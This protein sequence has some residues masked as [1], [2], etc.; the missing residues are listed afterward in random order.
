M[1]TLD[2]EWCVCVSIARSRPLILSATV[3]SGFRQPESAIA[4]TQGR[5]S[6]ARVPLS[7]FT[8]TRADPPFKLRLRKCSANLLRLKVPRSSLIILQIYRAVAPGRWTR[9]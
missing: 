5:G 6:D 8:T 7:L 9:S 3:C 4:G 2:N 1:T